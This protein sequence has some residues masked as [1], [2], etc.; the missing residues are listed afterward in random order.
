MKYKR[1]KNSLCSMMNDGHNSLSVQFISHKLAKKRT[2]K[3][4]LTKK[5]V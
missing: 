1:I 2:S 4:L 3:K 5:L